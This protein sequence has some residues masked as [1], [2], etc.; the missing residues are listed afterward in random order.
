MHAHGHGRIQGIKIRKI[1]YVRQ[2]DNCDAGRF[3]A[4]PG[5]GF[6]LLNY[7]R[8]LGLDPD[9]LKPGNHP[10]TG[11]SGL[12]SQPSNAL[13]KQAGIPAE[14]VDD[15]SLD[16]NPLLRGQAFQGAHDLGEHPALMDIRHQYHRRIRMGGDAKIDEIMGHQVYFSAGPR[17]LHNHRVIR[18]PQ[19]I[20][21]FCGNGEQIIFGRVILP[22][23]LV[24]HSLPQNHHLG[25][26]LTCGL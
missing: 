25:A 11:F 1:G 6:R 7:H 10:E 23:L 9:V 26:A 13:I 19:T 22:G 21:G 14:A 16:L 12:L 2:P 17:S 15:K 3:N 24:A 5:H 4:R 18:R 8:I 20:Q